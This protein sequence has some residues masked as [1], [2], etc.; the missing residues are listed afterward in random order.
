MTDNTQDDAF[1]AAVN[2]FMG[3]TTEIKV[4]TLTD[5]GRPRQQAAVLIDI[6]RLHTLF[7][8][9]AG[10]AYARLADGGCCL[11][12]GADYREILSGT[13]YRL[14]GKGANRNSIAET[15]STLSAIAKNDGTEEPVYLRVGEKDGAIVIDSGRADRACYVVTPDGWRFGT[16]SVNFRRSGKPTALPIAGTADFGLIW[17]YVNVKPQDRVLVA[18]WMVAAMRP[19]G[20]YPIL[21]WTG[22]QGTAKSASARTLKRLTDPSVSS[23]RS[24]PRDERDLLVAA[25]SSWVLAIDNLSG[26]DPQLSD[27][28]CR[29]ST[30]GGLSGRKLYTDTDEVL[31]DIMRPVILNGI[32]EIAG[33]PDM[34]QRCIHIE[35]PPLTGYISEADLGAAF[36]EDAGAIFAALLDA[37]AL[38]L[39]D[40]KRVKIGKVPRM[41]D[42]AQWA[43]AGLPALGFTQDEFLAAYQ[44]NQDKAIEAG[45]ESSK[46][47][48]AVIRFMDGRKEWTGASADLLRKLAEVA[49]E[50]GTK[51]RSWPQSPKGLVNALRRLG[52]SLRHA[53]IAWT[54]DDENH[55]KRTVTLCTVANK[56][57]QAPQAPPDNG[58]SAHTALRNPLCTRGQDME[59]VAL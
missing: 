18:A 13:Y 30:G 22:E 54:K 14:T 11:I 52:P 2:D 28:F 15:I 47:G 55:G 45:L 50:D 53:G 41:A 43:A 7:H 19:R 46:I 8:D 26:V 38:A 57:P 21:A 49:G 58:T 59:E 16:P 34:A 37:V 20:P 42:F 23:L 6:G 3:A 44:S 10:D 40:V 17:R 32:D 29:I 31:Y 35:A 4:E 5:E 48:Q 33:R 39:R 1:D 24:P 27:A 9:P 51:N 25:L 56:A 12:P 36:Q